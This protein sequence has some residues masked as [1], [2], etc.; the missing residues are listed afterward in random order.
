MHAHKVKLVKEQANRLGLSIIEALVGDARN[1]SSIAN[2]RQFDRILIDAPC[3]GLGVIRRKPDIKWTKTEDSVAQIAE[4]QQEILTAVAPRLRKGG[5]LV[6][7][8]CTV[9]KAENEEIINAFL[10]KNEQFVLDRKMGE[11][12]PSELAEKGK[13][14]MVTIFPHDYQTDGFFIAC[15]KRKDD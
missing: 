12:L 14:G 3:S 15:L 2:G 9:D 4:V 13:A 7:S 6:Y 10:E 5:L 8:T 11:R 1:L